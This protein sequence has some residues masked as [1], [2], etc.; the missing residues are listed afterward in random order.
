[1]KY[2]K[3][4]RHKLAYLIGAFLGDGCCYINTKSKKRTLYQFFI[5]SSDYDLVKIC[6]DISIDLF[7]KEGSISEQ[8]NY[9]YLRICSKKICLL[10]RRITNGRIKIPFIKPDD[11]ETIKY[12][13]AGLVD[14]DGYICKVNASDG[15]IRYRMGYHAASIFISDLM[16]LLNVVG[17]KTGKL[18]K[19]KKFKTENQRYAFSV[20][21]ESF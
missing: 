20:N 14:S 9:Y 10:L 19:R 7:G 16:N 15:Y 12:L 3:T 2:P 8:K 1:M 13:C 6:R 11:K 17:V 18:G 5:T 21:V 4:K